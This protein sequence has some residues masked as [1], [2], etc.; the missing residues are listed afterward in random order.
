MKLIHKISSLLR[1]ANWWTHIVPVILAFYYLSLFQ[2]KG[3]VFHH[4]T[5]FAILLFSVIGTAAFGFILNEICDVETDIKA[6]KKNYAADQSK[7]Q[8][9]IFIA[10]AVFMSVFP[11]LFVGINSLCIVLLALQFIALIT[12]SARPFRLKESK[13]GSLLLD[14]LYSSV[15]FVLIAFLF[16]KEQT[17]FRQNVLFVLLIVLWGFAKG[18]RNILMHQIIDRKAD[19]KSGIISIPSR[20]PLKTIMLINLCLLPIELVFFCL[21]LVKFNFTLISII[22]A[23]SIF[24]FFTISKYRFWEKLRIRATY[25]FMLFPRIANDLY[26]EWFPFLVLIL[27]GFEN[28]EYFIFLVIHTFL[29]NKIVLKFINDFK[30]I[31]LNYFSD[32]LQLLRLLK[33]LR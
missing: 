1:V 2:T 29:F 10:C 28:N 19:K 5:D 6:G 11:W 24:I 12:Y 18:L 9:I 21:L 22:F 8:K 26:E 20:A 17:Y 23:L 14:A 30:N 25:Y 7:M 33:L 31:A 3:D 27:L 15:F 13:L 32:F 4:L 16:S